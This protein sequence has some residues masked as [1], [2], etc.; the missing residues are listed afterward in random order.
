M[1]EII[2][3]IQEGEL[4]CYTLSDGGTGIVIADNE[5]EAEKKVRTAYSKHGGYEEGNLAS[6]E[7]NVWEITQKPF[8]D[9]PDVLE[10]MG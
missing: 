2:K 8:D 7:V 6:V 10:I 4:W 9:A 1:K 5:E 3:H